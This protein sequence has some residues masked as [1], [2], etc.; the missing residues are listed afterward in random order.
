[1]VKRARYDNLTGGTGDY[2]PQ[3]MT[4]AAPQSG[5]DTTTTTTLALPTEKVGGGSSSSARIIEI[6]KVYFFW[7]STL[8]ETDNTCSAYLST[9]NFGTTST[10]FSEPTVFAAMKRELCLTTS[11]QAI[12]NHPVTF[13]L[14]DGAGHGFLVATDN[15]YVQTQSANTAQANTVRVKILYRFKQ[16]GTLEYVG[17]VQGQS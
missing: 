13:D 9:K 7:D 14:T 11:G 8:I 3:L 17:I 6:L 15:I 2:S 5:N 16:V 10:T 1:M 4:I 12:N